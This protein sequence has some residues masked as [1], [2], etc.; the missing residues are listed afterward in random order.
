MANRD[1]EIT[2]KL[3]AEIDQAIKGLDRTKQGINEVSRAATRANADIARSGG[4]N[5]QFAA[6]DA[7]MR[8]TAKTARELQ[9]ATRGLP[10]QFTDIGVSLASGQRPMMVLLQQGGQLKDMFGGI[11]P[12]ARAMGGYITGLINPFTLA[13]AASV[14]LVAA[15]KVG[16]DEATAFNQ[17]LILTGN[18]ANATAA[19]LTGLARE[20]DNLAGI[21]THSASAA[22]AEVVSSG[23]FTEDQFKQVA[24]AAEQMRVAT[25]KSVGD[26]IKEFAKLK[27]DPVNALLE[28]NEK[29]RFLTQAQL[30]GVRSLQAQGR[31]TEAVTEAFRIY[32]DL[33]ESR[34]GAIVD[35]LGT[36]ERLWRGIKGAISESID[37]MLEFGREGTR[38]SKAFERALRAM[39]FGIGSAFSSALNFGSRKPGAGSTSAPDGPVV[40]SEEARKAIK[41]QEEQEEARRKFFEDGARYG[42]DREKLEQRILKMIAEGQAAGIDADKLRARAA[43]MRAE[44]EEKATK[45]KKQADDPN[46]GARRELD[47]LQKQVALLD[48]L[49]EGETKA[50]ES[51]RIHYEITEGAY[52]NASGALKA[53]L[54]E[55]ARA[56][57][58]ERAGIEA[59]KA[60]AKAFE[61]V[62]RAYE[63]VQDALRTPTEVALGTAIAQVET[64]NAALGKGIATKAEFDQAMGRVVSGAFTRPPEFAGLAPEVGGPA[65]EVAKTFDAQAELEAWYATQLSLLQQFRA[66]KIGTEADWNAQEQALTR[67][68]MDALREI[69]SA[70]QQATLASAAATFDQL[71]SIAKAY[72]GEQSRTY[73]AL[74]ALSRAF[75]VAQAAVALVNNVAEA[76][77]AGF[78]ANIPLIAG[79]LAQGAQIAAML[80]GATFSGGGGY[81]EGGYT[82]PGAK[83]QKAG[84]VHKG[85]YVQPQ[86]RMRERGALDFMRAFHATGMDAIYAWRGYADGGLVGGPAG[87]PQISAPRWDQ[88]Q[89]PGTG[90]MPPELRLNLINAFNV[91]DAIARYFNGPKGDKTYLNAVGRNRTA[92]KTVVMR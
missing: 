70:R 62:R 2:L 63:R 29:Q 24:I 42:S 61:E 72:G 21:T 86:E 56:L 57:D 78:P 46:E 69:E 55:Q 16:S 64:L 17:A 75:A 27:D 47:N 7:A 88:H 20:M 25:G 60:T 68:H 18:Q 90:A 26:T 76:S 73:R 65:G 83:Y 77:K 39:P 49:E 33:Y 13:A 52:R 15:W 91:D 92:T 30:D 32:A 74:F 12:A 58:L 6:T 4:A 79:A 50:S 31:E 82:G 66:Q 54:V 5:R 1:Y 51:A 53:Q 81:A 23:E 84:T 10:A 14:A 11:G 22:L 45:A 9:F 67:Q 87:A 71:A 43:Q 40:D 85:E 41:L 34:S 3:K 89:S 59:K 19:E 44:F 35:N 80:S 48:Q 37:A 8:S 36:V 28:L 38:A